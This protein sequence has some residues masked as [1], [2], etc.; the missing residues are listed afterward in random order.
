VPGTDERIEGASGAVDLRKGPNSVLIAVCWEVSPDGVSFELDDESGLP[1]AGLGNELAEIIDG[2]DRLDVAQSAA[3]KKSAAAAEDL[4]DVRIEY[5]NPRATEVSIIGSFNNWEA[6]ATPMSRAGKG[7]WAVTL[8][9]RTGRYPY[10]IL[11]NRKQK[12]A[13]PKNEATEPDGFGGTNSI[14]E[15]K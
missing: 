15:V 7:V 6:G 12:F 5:E 10:K 1:P 4:K 14:L 3:Q 13:D 2:F 9:L 8:H 11:V